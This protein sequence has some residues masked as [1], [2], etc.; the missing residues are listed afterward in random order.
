[1]SD[2]RE[3]GEIEQDADVLM[4]LY[5]DEVYD[6]ES[7]HAGLAELNIAKQRNGPLGMVWLS[8][9]GEY[10]R[11]ES[12]AVPTWPA[13]EKSKRPMSGFGG[14]RKGDEA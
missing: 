9:L 5:R 10:V 4:F 7:G 13:R 8:W 12:A 11:F 14:P 1:M 3:S 2:L 6:P